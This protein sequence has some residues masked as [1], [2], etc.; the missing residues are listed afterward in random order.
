LPS[1]EKGGNNG[2]YF[3][4][5]PCR[6]DEHEYRK[7]DENHFGNCLS[8]LQIEQEEGCGVPFAGCFRIGIAFADSLIG[9][10]TRV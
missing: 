5:D 9:V 4:Y 3:D 2:Q 1:P 10:A 7:E 8:V 6:V